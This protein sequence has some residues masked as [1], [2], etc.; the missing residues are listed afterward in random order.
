MFHQRVFILSLCCLLFFCACRKKETGLPEE[1]AIPKADNI[2]VLP[3][4][5]SEILEKLGPEND[6][7]THWIM[8]DSLF[9]LVGQPKKFFASPAGKGNEQFFTEILGRVLLIPFNLSKMERFVVSFA[10]G[11]MNVEVDQNGTK[12]FRPGLVFKRTLTLTFDSD[13]KPEDVLAPNLP[14]DMTLDSLKRKVGNRE[15]FDMTDPNPKGPQRIAMHFLDNRSLVIIEG[16]EQDIQILLG[17]ENLKPVSGVIDRAKRIDLKTTDL[18]LVASKEGLAFPPQILTDV[19]AAFQELPR[20]LAAQIAEHFRALSVSLKMEAAT[21]TPMLEAQ[22]DALN[23]K[24]ATDLVNLID[25]RIVWGQTTLRS[26]DE[27]AKQ[28]LP[29]SV[30]FAD[31]ALNAMQIDSKGNLVRFVIDKFEGFDETFSKGVDTQKLML[32]QTQ[33]Q[34]AR[35]EQLS[36]IA[37]AFLI[38]YQQHQK[39][40]TTI[41][42][43]DGKAL[44]S[45]R[46][47][48]LPVMGGQELYDRFKLNEPWDSE[49]NKTLLEAMPPIFRPLGVET[50]LLTQKTKT[51]IRLFQSE[52]MPLAD[53]K[54]KLEELENLQGTMLLASLLPSQ[55]VE[56]TKP[57]D[58]PWDI[59][60]IDDY[61]GNSFFAISFNGM[62]DAITLLPPDTEDGK[63][64]RQFI[65]AFARGRLLRQNERSKDGNPGTVPA[66]SSDETEI[67]RETPDGPTQTGETEQ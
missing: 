7:N 58:L 21:G 29:F 62:V 54:V 61:F 2:P 6:L 3:L 22:F 9:V 60:K 56:W 67:G 66:A 49:A 44:L 14:K 55:A 17:S 4:P 10:P 15:Y 1:A 11:I 5:S 36:M 40:P 26:L 42:S 52:S 19:L 32:Q 18:A 57:E 48:L 12:A 30:E 65:D 47:A 25:G 23:E 24:G 43:E 64:Q 38:Y 50:D 53:P 27:Q 13:I 39:I 35:H 31:N 34:Q 33:L 37:R 41:R 63:R 8:P 45:W 28:Y 59:D 51:I 46:V 20:D 16:F